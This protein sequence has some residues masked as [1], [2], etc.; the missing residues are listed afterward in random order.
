MLSLGEGDE[1][2]IYKV[3]GSWAAGYC[4]EIAGD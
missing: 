3:L 2:I 4:T 1:Q